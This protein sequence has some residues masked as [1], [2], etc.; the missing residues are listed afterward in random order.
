MANLPNLLELNRDKINIIKQQPIS[1]K[2][3][4]WL[5]KV[6]SPDVIWLSEY[7]KNTGNNGA[8]C[9]LSREDIVSIC[10]RREEKLENN[11]IK[12]LVAVLMWGYGQKSSPRGTYFTNMILGNNQAIQRIADA[13]A[14]LITESDTYK[15]YDK[16]I[17]LRGL[18]ISFA[19]KYLYF[20]GKAYRSTNYP[21]IYDKWVD[22]AVRHHFLLDSPPK[23]SCK[24]NI[25]IR[26]YCN[27]VD[28]MHDWSKKIN[29]ETENLE[30]FLFNEGKRLAG[31]K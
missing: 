28:S 17:K 20:F 6:S 22:C 26:R 12:V 29:C 27:Y 10:L 13:S 19:S 2:I 15:A 11:V 31:A 18:G 5:S 7:L 9:Q 8:N 30:L 14:T 16:L 21:L 3:D 25:N 4:K 1:I 23:L 24:S